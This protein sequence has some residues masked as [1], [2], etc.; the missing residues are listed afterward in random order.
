MK[1]TCYLETSVVSYL[2]AR[3][4]RDLIIAA[5]QQITHDWWKFRKPAFTLYASQLVLTEAGKGNREAV[6]KRL[7]V[8]DDIEL[9]ELKEDALDLADIFMRHKAVPKKAQEDALH[10]AL[11]AIY[12]LDY[13]MTWNCRHIANAE[14]QKQIKNICTD[15][16]YELPTI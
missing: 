13:L 2:T 7:Q 6:T 9:L 12:G 15:E 1:S 11:A 16:G 5:H 4:N 10:I 14:I 3:P 8:L